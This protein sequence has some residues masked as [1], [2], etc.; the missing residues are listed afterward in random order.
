MPLQWK[1][2][3]ITRKILS[4]IFVLFIIYTIIF[5]LVTKNN[6]EELVE[7][8]TERS[9]HLLADSIFIT[10]RN[11]MNTGDPQFIAQTEAQ[12]RTGLKG[13]KDLT[14]AKGKN[15][16]DIYSPNEEFTT[17]PVMLNAFKTKKRE[18]L[19][20]TIDG[21]HTIRYVQPMI[22]TN[23]CIACHTNDKAGDVVGV[24]SL[25]FSLDEIDTLMA[26]QSITIGGMIVTLFVVF[27][28]IFYFVIKS[29]FKPLEEL[30][31]YVTNFFKFV[32]NEV[33][34]IEKLEPKSHDEIGAIVVLV[35]N[36]IDM[37]ER[38]MLQ[39]RKVLH[40][41][42]SVIGKVNSG[43]FN[44]TIKNSAGSKEIQNL[45]EEINTMI[46]STEKNLTVLSNTLIS[47][48]R[49]EFN[50]KAPVIEGLTGLV[51]SML[52]GINVTGTTVSEVL[53]LID[54]SNKRLIFSAKDLTDAAIKLNG[55]SSEQASSLEE[56]AAAIE[57]VAN[58]I[59]QSSKNAEEMSKYAQN[60]TK[61]SQEG[62]KLASQT[63]QAMNEISQQVSS[64][65]EA[66]TVID[67]IAF[68]TNILSLNA[69]V[70]AAT[71]GE[72]GKG[73][74]VVAQEVRNLANR[75][76]E[77][78]REIKN[79]VELA[80]SKAQ[81]GKD[82]A[83][84]MIN[85]YKEL[86]EN[87]TQTISLIDFVASSTKEQNIA[88][89]QINKAV[90]V[91]DNKT[92]ENAIAAE[93]IKGM[94]GETEILASKL[95]DVVDLTKYDVDGKRRVCDIGMI[96]DVAQLKLDHV[97]FKN[98]AFVKCKDGSR[99]TVTDH[100]SCNLGKWINKHEG[101]HISTLPEWELLKK[102]HMRVHESVQDVVDLYAGGYANGQIIAVSNFV[103][104]NINNTFMYLDKLKEENCTYLRSKKG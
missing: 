24:V 7:S 97:N 25:T 43:I 104:Q 42:K 8:Q 55:A 59:K 53:A 9:I 70:E 36:N 67:Q 73:F 50:V 40:E 14:V 1:N 38:R 20:Q 76:A 72:A 23:E 79:I 98:D 17:D 52:T 68:Q 91:L 45:V 49:S 35:N 101:S 21:E 37:T 41:A 34:S 44:E 32:N 66:I 3:T 90:Q 56:T 84:T 13:L 94:A 31:N 89:E 15:T 85:G 103:E 81:D 93:K 6:A 48:G 18:L 16:I 69:A 11:S 39:D 65:N 46:V 19:N 86:N 78:A 12:V 62:E 22:A 87:I 82:I 10:L 74:A 5:G 4:L 83:A 99:F 102:S 2:L 92:Q 75:S 27:G 71:A 26:Q 58:T 60:V 80:N 57:E 61:S 29:T 54:N 30:K 63:T 64:I 88:M 28:L 47:Y 77:A 96:F 100:H 51:Q 33:D 95:H